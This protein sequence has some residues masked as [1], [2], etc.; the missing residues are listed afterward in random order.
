MPSAKSAIANNR[1]PRILVRA[2]NWIGDT[3]MSMPA[4]QRLREF[5]PQAHITLLCPA[6]LQDIWRRNPFL[7]EVLPSDPRPDVEELR[8]REFDLAIIFPNSF[9]AAWECRRAQIPYRVGFPGH[10]RRLMLT[11]V[12]PEPPGDKP[13]SKEIQVAGRTF[14][15]KAFPTLRHQVHRYDCPP[16]RQP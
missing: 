12:V 5:K 2:T 11:D 4:I 16:R 9:R 1:N 8:E 7:N 3:V 13:H 15:V 10:S 14:K 6:K